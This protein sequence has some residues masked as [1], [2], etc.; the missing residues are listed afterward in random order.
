VLRIFAESGELKGQEECIDRQ[1]DG[2]KTAARPRENLKNG[3]T[4]SLLAER[5]RAG[6]A[7]GEFSAREFVPGERELA[8][9]HSVARM[10]ARRALKTL[11]GE[12]LIAAR[13]GKGYQVLA[14]AGDPSLGCPVA[15]LLSRES[16]I[17]GWDFLYRALGENLQRCAE[18]RGWE[19]LSLL[20]TRERIARVLE[21]LKDTRAWGLVIDSSYPEVL[22]AATQA[23]M[24]VV[25]I[26]SWD[27]NAGYDS[28]VQDNFG[29][30]EA[31]VAH[32]IERG[33]KR[34][35]WFGP[36]LNS[37]HSRA[38]Y[39]S[40]TSALAERGLAFSHDVRVLL[41]DSDVISSARKLLSGKQ[42]PSAILAF[43]RPM[44][45]ALHLAARDL[46]LE[47]GKDFE[48]IGWCAEETYEAGFKPIFNGGYVPPTVNWSAAAMAEAAIN[49]LE[50]R[51]TKPDMP[52][53]RITV[54]AR[55]H[56]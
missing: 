4:S 56:Q 22:G 34:I 40:A 37:F 12:G 33:H 15:F 47:P 21:Q 50:E 6:I 27:Q 41:T 10:T 38:R 16:I 14:R 52:P 9:T 51:R 45:A 7:K 31:A 25:S 54:P 13:P 39:G 48:F 30:A 55:V 28:I 18:E 17:G 46:N 24:P 42:R 1:E 8:K 36:T 11:E 5:L 19:L 3:P 43:W 53:A 20:A 49:R 35:A 26:D 44:A 2:M 32:L 23:G 29:G